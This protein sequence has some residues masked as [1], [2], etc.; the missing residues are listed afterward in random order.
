MCVSAP[1]G[2][3]NA[4]IARDRNQ[5]DWSHG[6]PEIYNN[7]FTSIEIERNQPDCSHGNPET[8]TFGLIDL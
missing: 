8:Y 4:S 3:Q 1:C 6:N 7:N 5:P 2:P